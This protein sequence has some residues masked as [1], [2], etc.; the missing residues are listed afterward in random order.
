MKLGRLV[1]ERRT[2]AEV[3]EIRQDQI[4]R[5]RRGGFT[6]SAD[7]AQAKLDRKSGK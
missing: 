1:V 6:K 7:K 5:I 3:R 2:D 4:D